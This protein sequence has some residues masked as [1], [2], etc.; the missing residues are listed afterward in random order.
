MV[1]KEEEVVHTSAALAAADFGSDP[2]PE[3]CALAPNVLPPCDAAI[4]LLGAAAR[5]LLDGAGAVA[6]AA[7]SVRPSPWKLSELCLPQQLPM[8]RRRRGRT[9]AA[10]EVGLGRQVCSRDT[11]GQQPRLLPV[12]Q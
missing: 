1:R 4:L 6:G 2:S 9:G 11:A 7:P 8:L 5:A 3:P 12:V 10:A